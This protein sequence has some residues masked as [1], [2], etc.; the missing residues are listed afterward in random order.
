M[1]E[2]ETKKFQENTQDEKE[3]KSRITDDIESIIGTSWWTIL[4]MVYLMAKYQ[5]SCVFLP[6]DIEPLSE[7]DYKFFVSKPH[8]GLVTLIWDARTSFPVLR[9]PR[10]FIQN[11]EA[12]AMEKY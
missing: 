12:E 6:V 5:N 1:Q 7:A 9:P 11:D 10:V 3:Y 8:S 2:P 4:Q